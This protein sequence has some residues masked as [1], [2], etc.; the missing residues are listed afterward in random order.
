VEVY[1]NGWFWAGRDQSVAS[2]GFGGHG[3]DWTRLQEVLSRLQYLQRE[4]AACWGVFSVGD[5]NLFEFQ[6][7]SAKNPATWWHQ[8]VEGTVQLSDGEQLQNLKHVYSVDSLW[9]LRKVQQPLELGRRAIDAPKLHILRE[10]HK[11]FIAFQG[12]L[13]Q[14]VWILNIWFWFD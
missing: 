12:S 2:V 4:M 14:S 6:G 3:R 1:V 8:V 11:W 9:R 7:F 5:V 13:S 10:D